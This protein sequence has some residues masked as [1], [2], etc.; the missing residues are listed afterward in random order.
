M[1]HIKRLFVLASMLFALNLR[2][3]VGFLET[4]AE[5]AKKQGAE[6]IILFAE[7]CD[8]CTTGSILSGYV[9]TQDSLNR[10]AVRYIKYSFD[11]AELEVLEDSTF[12]DARI[13]NIFKIVA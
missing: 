10:C 5:D 1:K 8:M 6:K 3:Q 12:Y 7:Q 2:A 11:Y 13:E 9:F 4:C